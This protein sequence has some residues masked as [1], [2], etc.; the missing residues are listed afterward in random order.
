M[1][2]LA[3][4]PALVRAVAAFAATTALTPKVDAGWRA[5]DVILNQGPGGANRI[6]FTPGDPKTGR[7]GPLT[8]GRQ[9]Q[10]NPR[11]LWQW[12]RLVFVCMWGVDTSDTHD[13]LKQ[14]SATENLFE[15]TMQALQNARD[16]QTSRF[17]GAANIQIV[18]EPV[19]SIEN[20]EM[21]FGRELQLPITLNGSLFDVTYEIA[22]PQAAV[23]RSPITP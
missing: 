11:V 17:V 22:T 16:P 21:Y 5:R 18:G 3:P 6:V 12:N 2:N 14:Q 9:A 10:T 19:W 15:L 13:E 7:A 20:T 8:R 23:T 4:L 1:A